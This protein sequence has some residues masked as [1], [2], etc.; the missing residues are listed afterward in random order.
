MLE[1]T[2]ATDFVPGSNLKGEVAGANWLFLLPRIGLHRVVC[3]GMPPPS[4]LKTLSNFSQELILVVPGSLAGITTAVT[5]PIPHKQ[6]TFANN[7]SF[8]LPNKCADLVVL[9]DKKLAQQFGKKPLLR[10]ELVRLLTA[11][12]LIYAEWQAHSIFRSTQSGKNGTTEL[13]PTN[14]FNL[15]PYNGEMHTAVPTNDLAT[16]SYFSQNRLTSPML[17]LSE[18]MFKQAKRFA[19]P[20]THSSRP[21]PV[22]T[23]STGISKPKQAKKKR[24][25]LKQTTRKAGQ[26]LMGA[27]QRL[28][29]FVDQK[30][31]VQRYGAFIAVAP[32]INNTCPPQ[33]LRTIAASSNI[34]LDNYRWGLSARGEYSSRKMLFFLFD[35]AKGDSANRPDYIVKMV[36]DSSFNYRLD[37]EAQAL[38]LLTAKE[39]FAAEVLPKVVFAGHHAGLSIVGESIID[40]SPFRQKSAATANCPYGRDALNWFVDLGAATTDTKST[41]PSEIA[42]ALNE[43]LTC[44]MLIDKTLRL[45]SN[46]F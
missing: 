4:T 11:N 38:K 12:G 34:N 36:R 45:S 18:N 42:A 13:D 23:E 19:P 26:G 25:S 43:L 9:A 1:M 15:T 22:S 33:Y 3:I 16:N 8:P 27:V 17:N 37:N 39:L 21:A 40:G 14:L 35:C 41:T 20:K 29:S 10:H 31:P 30:Q 24:P 2:L 7:N 28:E 46:N 5:T 32:G 6:I 44:F